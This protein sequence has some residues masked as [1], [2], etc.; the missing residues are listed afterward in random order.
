[1]IH[2]LSKSLL[3]AR[4][5]NCLNV[6]TCPYLHGKPVFGPSCTAS[7]MVAHWILVSAQVHFGL[8][9]SFN[10]GTWLGLGLR[11]GIGGLGLKKHLSL[12]LSLR[13]I[14]GRLRDDSTL[15]L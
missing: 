6:P 10:S 8:I 12:L 11:G 3:A 13:S 14:R 4:I 1:M 9:G 15:A 2:F 5:K 7:G